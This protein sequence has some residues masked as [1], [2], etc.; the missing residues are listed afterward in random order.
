MCIEMKVVMLLH[1]H[2]QFAPRWHVVYN[3]HKRVIWPKRTTALWEKFN[4]FCFDFFL[5]CFVKEDANHQAVRTKVYR[6]YVVFVIEVVVYNYLLCM[7]MMMMMMVI[8]EKS[9][10]SECPH[11]N[12]IN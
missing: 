4:Y 12:Y 10:K 6:V 2:R 7:C 11:M 5:F 1:S 8:L 9:D 3:A